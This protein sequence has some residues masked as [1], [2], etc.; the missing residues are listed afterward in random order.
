MSNQS[1]FRETGGVK[2]LA[3]LL[4]EI[5]KE[6]ETPDGLAEWAKPQHDKN[7]WG[8]VAVLRLFLVKGGVGTKA[9]QLA[10]W[11][12]GVLVEVILLAFSRE[13]DVAIRAEVGPQAKKYMVIFNGLLMY[14]F[15]GSHHLCRDYPWK[16]G[17][18]GGFRAGHGLIVK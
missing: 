4:G 3:T 18:S 6:Q 11:Q 15:S 5:V 7:V 12:S 13:L 10:F 16:R 1:F 14:L 2:R 17:Y 9:N 8:F